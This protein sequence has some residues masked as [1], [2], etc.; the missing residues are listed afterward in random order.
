MDPDD[1]SPSS[2]DI[3]EPAIV[4]GRLPERRFQGMVEVAPVDEEEEAIHCLVIIK[5][6]GVARNPLE[7]IARRCFRKD[8]VLILPERDPYC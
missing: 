6:Q 4:V 2:Q 1:L 7:I 8:G 5:K 3:A